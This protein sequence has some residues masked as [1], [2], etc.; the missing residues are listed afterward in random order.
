MLS[1]VNDLYLPQRPAVT[2][3]MLSH[4]HLSAL[5]GLEALPGAT[6][7]ELLEAVTHRVKST[8]SNQ[9]WGVETLTGDTPP[10]SD[11]F[12]CSVGD[13]M[14]ILGGKPADALEE[15]DIVECYGHRWRCPGRDSIPVD[16]TLGDFAG[17]VFDNR[18]YIIGSSEVVALADVPSSSGVGAPALQAVL[19]VYDFC[20][21]C[22]TCFSLPDHPSAGHASLLAAHQ[23]EVILYGRNHS[24]QVFGADNVWTFDTRS[25]TWT[26]QKT[27]GPL[28][29]AHQAQ[30]MTVVGSHAYLL[31]LENENLVVH[32]LDLQTWRW[33]CLQYRQRFRMDQDDSLATAL[34]DNRYWVVHGGSV[35]GMPG[36][37]YCNQMHAFD[38]RDM[39]WQPC[40]LPSDDLGYRTGHMATCHKGQILIVGGEVDVGGEEDSEGEEVWKG[41]NHVLRIWCDPLPDDVEMPTFRLRN[42]QWASAQLCRLFPD[43][44][45]TAGGVNFPV[46]RSIL[47]AHSTFF[48]RLFSSCM[49][50]GRASRVVLGD[51]DAEVFRLAVDWMYGCVDERLNMQQAAH[52]M[53]AGD[54]L[55]ILGLRDASARICRDCLH[56]GNRYVHVEEGER[57]LQ[58]YR[59][60][61]AVG[62][63]TMA[64]VSIAFKAVPGP[65]MQLADK[66]L[67]IGRVLQCCEHSLRNTNKAWMIQ[68][69]ENNI[70]PA[71]MLQ[72]KLQQHGKSSEASWD[73]A[74]T[75]V[76]DVYEASTEACDVYEASTEASVDD[77]G[78]TL[79]PCEVPWLGEDDQPSDENST[80][81]NDTDV[82]E[83]GAANIMRLSRQNFAAA[84]ANNMGRRHGSLCQESAGPE[85]RSSCQVARHTRPAEEAWPPAEVCVDG[86]LRARNLIMLSQRKAGA[87]GGLGG[88][89]KR[90]AGLEVVLDDT[91]TGYQH[92]PPISQGHGPAEVS[93]SQPVSRQAASKPSIDI[94]ARCCSDD[95]DR[96]R[97]KAGNAGKN[98]WGRAA[99][100]WGNL[101][102]TCLITGA[103]AGLGLLAAAAGP[104]SS[105]SRI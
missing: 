7:Q 55:S 66:L 17:V 94:N 36:E 26:Q 35:E 81:V 24:G 57:V 60:A 50:E 76:S 27:S 9:Q 90:V 85:A 46:H 104:S 52:M 69:E 32:E 40:I 82:N 75:L 64:D 96:S 53:R 48:E 71:P 37:G 61:M 54:R 70:S 4:S 33:R 22:W 3:P 31:E 44:T 49:Q 102:K 78:S 45:V 20:F 74:S 93:G 12:V 47:S 84:S 1:E 34:L 98:F 59:Y 25:F 43:A 15:P 92:A 11:G 21:T 19:R 103:V 58:V 10:R 89:G 39:H 38:F 62:D 65:Q 18:L 68:D 87:S 8:C 14:Y 5:A 88:T 95:P 80:I 79:D 86:Q 2:L 30:A 56:Y 6:T 63:Y 72:T 100:A 91:A 16:A 73:Q 51:M 23:N 28:P 67:L 13:S 99:G 105:S 101:T 29:C 97:A 83:L 77:I 42:C 41:Q